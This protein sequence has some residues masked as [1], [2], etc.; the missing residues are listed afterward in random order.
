M[1]ASIIK[2]KAIQFLQG[3]KY[4]SKQQ[5][6]DFKSIVCDDLNIEKNEENFNLIHE[7]IETYFNVKTGYEI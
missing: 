5:V 3:I 1:D 2:F 7:A 6:L 4:L